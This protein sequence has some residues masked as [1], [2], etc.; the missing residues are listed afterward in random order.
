MTPALRPLALAL[1]V[2][3]A[4]VPLVAGDLPPGLIAAELLP[5]A[6]SADGKVMTALRLELAKSPVSSV[7]AFL[8]QHP[9][10]M[11]ST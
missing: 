9:A 1:A 5:A 3:A 7:P 2:L 8:A 10:A 6:P 4:P 11:A